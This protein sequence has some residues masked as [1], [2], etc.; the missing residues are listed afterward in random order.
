MKPKQARKCR[1]MLVMVGV[2]VMLMGYFHQAFLAIGA[3][4]SFSSF[5]P[6][7][8]YNRCPHCGRLLGRNE[9]D[10]CQYCGGHIDD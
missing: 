2:V 4:I 6:D 5:I 3:F 7:L 9:G 1:N 8:W 10:Y